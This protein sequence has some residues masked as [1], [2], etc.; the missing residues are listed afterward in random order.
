VTDGALQGRRRLAGAFAIAIERI[1]PDPNQPRSKLDPVAQTELTRSITRLGIL[2]PISV[3]FIK[4]DNVYQ[5][6][7]GERRFQAAKTAGLIEIP[8]WIQDP[9][10]EEVLL[11]QIVE[12]WQRSDLQPFDL[13]DSLSRLKDTTGFSQKEL[14]VET[15]KS[16]GEIS[17]LFSILTLDPDVQKIAR[18]DTSDR[19]TKRHLY[20]LVSCSPQTQRAVV[21]H[22]LSRNLTVEDT[23]RMVA[24]EKRKTKPAASPGAP[25]TRLKFRTSNATVLMIFRKKHVDHNDILAVLNEVKRQH[26]RESSP[27]DV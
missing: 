14:A 21:E 13:A 12:N 6:I 17:K 11:H 10:E 18:D 20:T 16:E 27:A 5:I 8:C 4:K 9:D 19:I 25:V 1:R 15:G 3:R 26:A 22:V 2:Q 24:E 23:D 7:A